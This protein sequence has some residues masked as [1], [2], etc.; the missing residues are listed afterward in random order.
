MNAATSTQVL[1]SG[2]WDG[3]CFARALAVVAVV[4]TMA[5]AAAGGG[6]TGST[7]FLV[8]F[9][10]FA[11]GTFVGEQYAEL[12][13]TFS[14]PALPGQLPIVAVE[15]GSVAAFI[16]SGNDSPMSS[17]VCGLTDPLIN[18]DFGVGNN[19]AMHFDPPVTSVRFFVVDID[20]PESFTARAYD[21]MLEVASE[22][23]ATGQPGTGNGVSTEFFLSGSNITLVVLEVPA[24]A[25]FAIDFLTFTRRCEGVGCGSYIEIAQESSPGVGDFDANVIG[26]LS[27]YAAVAS[28]AGFYAYDVPEGDSWNG[29]SLTPVADRSHLL[30]A[31]TSDGM[32]LVIVHDRAIP[33]DPNGGRAE[34]MFELTGDAD[35]AVRTVEDDPTSIKSGTGYTGDAGDS[36]FTAANHWATCCTD[37]LVL[38]DLEGDWTMLVQFTEVNGN[39]STP[40][41]LGLLEWVAYSADGTQYPLALTTD[42]RVR[43]RFVGQS[44][45]PPDIAPTGGDGT[46]NVSDLLA[47]INGWGPCAAPC[48]PS[49]AADTNNDCDVNVSDL[50]AVINFWGPCP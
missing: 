43:L 38:S 9:E 44:L 8:D 28:A 41:I 42:R 4:G 22:T 1:G 19:I 16:G 20:T 14:I 46:V 26:Y 21:G 6:Q 37:G 47:V 13:V 2:L 3:L 25:G 30:L 18:G 24:V 29:Q 49:C 36:V 35:G 23:H 11:E 31:Q 5:A 33:D 34:M 39:A 32:S 17:G 15:G 27:A 48:P 10:G 12:G 50:L 45:C 7:L 40:P